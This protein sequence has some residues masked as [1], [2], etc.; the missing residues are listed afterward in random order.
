MGLGITDLTANTAAL[1]ASLTTLL[2]TESDQAHI[3]CE[4][5]QQLARRAA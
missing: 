3:T 1:Q 4:V 2:K 5:A